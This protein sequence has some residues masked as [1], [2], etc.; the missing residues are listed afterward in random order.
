MSQAIKS[1]DQDDLI[2]DVGGAPFGNRPLAEATLV[3]EGFNRAEYKVVGVDGGF[4]IKY[5]PP[6]KR[7]VVALEGEDYVSIQI[8]KATDINQIE[9]PE[10]GVNGE[11]LQL[12]RG[13]PITVPRR[14]YEALM[15]AVEERLRVDPITNETERV[16]VRPYA[17][18]FLG[19]S[20]QEKFRECFLPVNPQDARKARR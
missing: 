5:T 11:I 14:Y 2:F 20:T 4:A 6:Q 8:E 7:E 18:T 13:V 10:V 9:R 17:V 19:T 16:E 3:G 15:N 1:K 12:Q